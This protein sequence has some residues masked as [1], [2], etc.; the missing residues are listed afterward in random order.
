MV[1]GET[2]VTYAELDARA[3]RI[4]GEL[5]GRGAGRGDSVGVCLDRDDWLIA[6]LLGV[7]RAGAAYVPLD[8]AYPAD[9]L[10]FIAADAG[11]A[12][13]ITSEPVACRQEA[14]LRASGAAALLIESLPSAAAG[15]GPSSPDAAGSDAAYVIYTSG[16]TGRPKG[17]IVEHR[18]VMALLRHE[19]TRYQ[20]ELGGMLFATSVCFDPSVTQMFLPLLCGGTVIV[21]DNL[22]ALSALPARDEVSTVYGAPSALVALL[23]EPLPT[24][25]RMVIAGGEPL[26]R[27]LADRI[28]AN[29]GVRRVVNVYG[30]TECTVTCTSHE[31]LRDEDGEPPIGSAY[32]GSVLTVRDPEG[33]TLADGEIGELWVAGPLVGRGYLNRPALT[34]ERFVTDEEGVRH[35]RTGDLVRREDGIC[36]YAGRNDDQVK[37][38][39]FRVELGEVQGSLTRHPGVNH[40]VVLTQDDARGVRRLVAYVQPSEPVPSGPVPSGAKPSEPVPSEPQ[41][42]ELSSAG[43]S[44][45]EVPSS[46]LTEAGLREW[47]RDRLPDYM[48]PSRIALMERIPL[49]PTG[50]VDRAALPTLEFAPE[51]GPYVAP[52]DDTERRLAEIVGA[53]LGVEQVGVHHHFID[54]G[55]ESLAAARICA[56]I[57]RELGARVALTTFLGRPT[58][59]ELAPLVVAAA[60]AAAPGSAAPRLTRHSGRDRYPLTA[61][62]HGMWLLREVSRTQNATTLAFRLRLTGLD[63]A[64]PVRLALNALVREHEVLRTVTVTGPDGEPM[65]EVRAPAPVPLEEHRNA[66]GLAERLA[67][68]GFDLSADVPLLRAALLWHDDQTTEQTP[69]PAAGQTAGQATQQTAGVAAGHPAGRVAELVVVTDHTAY[70]GWS[71]AALM[72]ALTGVVAEQPVQVGDIALLEQELAADHARTERLRAFWAEE[73]AGAEPPYDLSARA[74]NGPS[75][76]RG[77]RLMRSVPAQTAAGVGEL[78]AATG[79]TPFAVY[80][81][82]LGL[83]VAAQTDRPDVLLGAAVA[84]RAHPELEGLVGPLVDVLPVRLRLDGR[85]SVRRAITQAAAATT[86]SLDHIGLAP[87]ERLAVSGIGRPRGTM[88]TPVVLSYQPPAVPVRLERDGRTVELLGELSGGGAQAPYTLFVNTTVEGVEIQVEYDIDHFTREEAESFADRLMR[89]LEAA[90]AGPDLP[91]SAFELVTADERATLLAWGGGAPLP[92]PGSATVVHEVLEHAVRHPGRVAVAD[93]AGELTYAELAEVSARVA[94]ALHDTFAAHPA[95]PADVPGGEGGGGRVVGVCLPRDRHLPAALVGVARAGAA[96]VPLEPDHPAERLRHQLA[97]SGAT[98]VLAAGDTLQ[99]ARELAGATGATV[100]DLA[101]LGQSALGQAVLGQAVPGAQPATPPATVPGDLAYVLYTSGSTGRPKGVEVTHA[102]LTAFVAAMR[103]T[104]GVRDD[105]V[106]LGLTPFS[107]DVFGFD[108]WVSLCNGLRL[109]MLDRAGAVDG[110]AVAARID[111]AGVTLFTAT[112]T[113]LRMLVAAGWEGGDRV[114]VVSIGEVLDPALAGELLV[115]VGELWNSYG[116]TET[117]VYSTM[118]RIGTPVGDSVSIGGPLPG[119]RAYVLDQEGR[120]VPPG[121]PGELWIGGSGVARGYRGLSVATF[122]DDPLAPG[123]RRYRTG[124]LACWRPDGTLDFLGRRDQQVKIRGHRIELGEIEAALRE[125]VPDAAVAV[126]GEHLVG[127]LV[128]A[129]DAAGMETAEVEAAL[130]EHL[131]E[132]MVPRQWISLDR[133]PTT[134]SGKVDRGALPKPDRAAGRPPVPPGSDAE[135]LVADVW[136]A[137]L[138]LEAVGVDDD[139][140]AVGG[141]SLAAML[142]TARLK[143][144]LALEVPVRLLFE[145][146]VLATFAVAIEELLVAELEEGR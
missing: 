141:H 139:F 81:T 78:A 120:L 77:A 75:R 79:T 99:T 17:V 130:R 39:G 145:R 5:R 59:A 113:T 91:L 43:R 122:A 34:A 142:V 24:G 94:A 131:P 37:V 9:R 40:A 3:E 70:D 71:N 96:Y 83:L 90:V 127:Y 30:P 42:A 146:P 14:V 82:V 8:P 1:A 93:G 31:V 116:P 62:Q 68:H 63:S 114:R 65:A 6:A 104:P 48:V 4:A 55:G 85:L 98:V 69:G 26:T 35:Y 64:E 16:S 144:A 44:S 50:K 103:I 102:N 60:Q 29:P 36:S 125:S 129:P 101:A 21:A 22:L 137:V 41:P 66:P 46:G 138:G 51:L 136:Q 128:G 23:S 19:A 115:R 124:D 112:P 92:E 45:S 12:H 119:E 53:V 95:A 28:Y 2:R 107:F 87:E 126:H 7:W 73:L 105:D 80:F 117:T 49:G 86:R 106:M 143:E 84:D 38:A 76:F 15:S 108:L 10:E 135:L 18:N 72:A 88:L 27:A 140:F 13:L 52:R 74:Q 89:L 123:E 132:Y 110:H 111:G 134:S 67:V 100:L 11:M 58:I 57:E 121:V 109:E 33:R 56:V 133:L 47:M 118:T 20:D 54:L 97:D 32:A 25:V 61:A